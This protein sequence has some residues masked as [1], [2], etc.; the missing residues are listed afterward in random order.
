MRATLVVVTL[1][2]AVIAGGFIVLPLVILA[3]P[4][5]VIL[6]GLLALYVLGSTSRG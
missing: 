4:L 2:V 3:P 1:V 5:P 6:A